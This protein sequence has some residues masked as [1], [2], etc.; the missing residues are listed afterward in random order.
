MAV[1]VYAS[2]TQTATIGTEHFVSSPSAAGTYTFHLDAAALTATD[3]LQLRVYQKVLSG[4]TARVVY[5]AQF[6]GVQPAD[7]SV[8]ISVP[9]STGLTESNALRF[10]LDQVSGTGRAFPWSVLSYG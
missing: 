9:I 2:G 7:D 5:F 6:D 10:S 8:K 1:T 3:S 4:G